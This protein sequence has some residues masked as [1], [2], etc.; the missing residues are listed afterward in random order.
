VIA[1]NH[2]TVSEQNTIT[3]HALGKVKL[4]I[5]K[6]MRLSDE[7]WTTGLSV[8]MAALNAS[9]NILEYT[10]EQLMFS[11]DIHTPNS[12][13]NVGKP[14]VNIQKYVDMDRH[15]YNHVFG[16]K[17][18]STKPLNDYTKNVRDRPTFTAGDR[19]ALRNEHL[20]TTKSG[21]LVSIFK[22]PYTIVKLN[23]D[24]FS[25]ELK[26]DASP[27]TE[28]ANFSRL[29]ILQKYVKT[30]EKV[31]TQPIV[32]TPVQKHRIAIYEKPM[33][34]SRAKSKH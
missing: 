34:R 20:N 4:A 13:D 18:V 7:N 22:G 33:T 26:H 5:N 2:D 19:V 12:S 21:A 29:K 1:E 10:P 8:F 16:D 25:C 24:K 27:I 31:I 14:Q 9:I 6:Y 28:I 30:E 3:K 32:N 11:T 23:D 17:N 15:Y